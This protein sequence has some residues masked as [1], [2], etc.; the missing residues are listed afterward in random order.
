[1]W[2]LDSVNANENSDSSSEAEATGNIDD[3]ET[4]EVNENNSHKVYTSNF[5]ESL[6]LYFVGEVIHNGMLKWR[7]DSIQRK[8][9]LMND[10]DSVSVNFKVY[11]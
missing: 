8:V 1:M 3:N 4:S 2:F 9:M 11:F 6:Y 7:E 10:Y 5:Q